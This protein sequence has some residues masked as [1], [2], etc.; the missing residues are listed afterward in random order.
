MIILN[1]MQKYSGGEYDYFDL[2]GT[3][4]GSSLEVFKRGWGVKEYAI[5]EIGASSN[6]SKNSHFRDIWGML[7]VRVMEKLAP[8]VIF[9]KI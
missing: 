4:V 8:W 1:V 2:G 3:R 6:S 7:P 5:Y 9:N